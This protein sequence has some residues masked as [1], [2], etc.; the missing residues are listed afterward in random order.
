VLQ[1]GNETLTKVP[2]FALVAVCSRCVAVSFAV[3]C[4]FSCS[5]LQC[6]A[7]LV[8]VCGSLLQC[9]AVC[10]KQKKSTKAPM[11]ALDAVCCKRVVVLVAVCCSISCSV[12]QY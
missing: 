3:S 11:L 4:S 1:T 5:V 8:A 7:V 9:V 10:C 12:L 2:L 6:V